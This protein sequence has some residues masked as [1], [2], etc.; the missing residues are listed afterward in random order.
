M[1]Y[2]AEKVS[3]HQWLQPDFWKERLTAKDLLQDLE[4]TGTKISVWTVINV[5]KKVSMP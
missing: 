3:H 1:T 2:G 5:M 4:A